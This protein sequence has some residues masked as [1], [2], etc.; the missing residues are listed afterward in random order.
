MSLDSRAYL[1]DV[2][3]AA[4]LIEEFCTGRDLDAFERDALFR[5]AVERQLMIVGEALARLAKSDAVLAERIPDLAKIIAF[6]NVI[7]HGYASLLPERT[8]S[9]VRDDLPQLRAL[10]ERLLGEA[11]QSELSP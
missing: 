6:R 11:G 2:S 10:V 9:S 4:A 3:T 1:W 5:S 8:W 7:V